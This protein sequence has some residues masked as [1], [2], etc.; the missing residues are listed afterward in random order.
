MSGIGAATR[1]RKGESPNPGGRPKTKLVS[2]ALTAKL[3]EVKPDDPLGRTFSEVVAEN[4]I[5]L[6]CTQGRSAVAAAIE[7]GN[8]VEG[9]VERF[10]FTDLSPQ[11][12]TRTDEELEH[13]LAHGD[14]PDEAPLT[15]GG[16][17]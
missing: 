9:R 13:Y 11:L 10:E 8:R 3:S 1:W 12:S 16:G 4:L 15:E 17:S 6:A 2:Q 14:W 5:T 7:I